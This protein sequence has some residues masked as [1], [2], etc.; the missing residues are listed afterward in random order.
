MGS[1]RGSH[2]RGIGAC[3][4][5]HRSFNSSTSQL[6]SPTLCGIAKQSLLSEIPFGKYIGLST[7]GAQQEVGMDIDVDFE[8]RG[9]G[10]LSGLPTRS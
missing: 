7:L 9:D 6:A 10:E 4:P 2:G 8:A 5:L 1:S 3:P